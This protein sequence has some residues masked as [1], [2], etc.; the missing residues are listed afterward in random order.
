MAEEWI[1]TEEAA[2]RLGKSEQIIRRLAEQ[3]TLAADRLGPAGRGGRWMI[4]AASV[5]ALR[6]EWE[7]NPPRRGRPTA[8]DPSAAALAK[9]RS[10]ERQQKDE[11]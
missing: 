10:R 4:S 3:G 8:A 7:K 6:A 11:A 5:E 9:R 1:S 2:T